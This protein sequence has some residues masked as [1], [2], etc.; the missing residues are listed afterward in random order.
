M[1]VYFKFPNFSQYKVY[2]NCADN[3]APFESCWICK[4]RYPG[5]IINRPLESFW[6]MTVLLWKNS[7][8]SSLKNVSKLQMK[9]KCGWVTLCKSLKTGQSFNND[10]SSFNKNDTDI[11]GS[12]VNRQHFETYLSCIS[13]KLVKTCQK[14]VFLIYLFP[15]VDGGWSNDRV[16]MSRGFLASRLL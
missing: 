15:I 3:S 5:R 11:L 9:R 4:S 6:T 16:V 12:L 8:P 7:S 10:T 14:T 1:V 2:K 13:F